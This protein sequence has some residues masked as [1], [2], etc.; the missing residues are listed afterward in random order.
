MDACF[1]G[2]GGDWNAQGHTPKYTDPQICACEARG[3]LVVFIYLLTI[4][5]AKC[6]DSVNGHADG[7]PSPSGSIEEEEEAR[8][9]ATTRLP[10]GLRCS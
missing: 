2:R 7:S 4:Q 3:L 10:I 6:L 5:P 8:R 9:P 1:T